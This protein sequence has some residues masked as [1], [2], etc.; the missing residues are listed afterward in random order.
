MDCADAQHFK[1]LQRQQVALFVEE[2]LA[3][4]YGRL[5]SFVKQTESQLGDG[6]GGGGAGAAPS[7]DGATVESL[8][9][10]FASSWKSGIEHINTSVMTY[11]SNFRNGME[12]LKQ[13]LTQ[14]LLYYTRFQDI[15]KQ[16]FSGGKQPPFFKEI[17]SI[18]TIMYEIKKVSCCPSETKGRAAAFQSTRP[19][20][21]DLAAS[22]KQPRVPIHDASDP[23]A[24]RPARFRVLHRHGLSSLSLST[25]FAATALQLFLRLVFWTVCFVIVLVFTKLL[26]GRRTSLVTK[27]GGKKGREEERKA[28]PSDVLIFSVLS[29]QSS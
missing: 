14:L 27:P 21:D 16:V 20:K 10:D 13:V 5:I 28:C 4:S 15:L 26:K 25:P 7:V 8:V 11:F 1:E 23:P 19:P 22:E 2:E 12:I 3:E 9:R 29:R 17:V 24:A 6:G 18:P